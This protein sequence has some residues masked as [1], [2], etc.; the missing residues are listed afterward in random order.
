MDP[1]QLMGKKI[2]QKLIL[3]NLPVEYAG[4]VILLH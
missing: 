1:L 2:P 3:N 4:A